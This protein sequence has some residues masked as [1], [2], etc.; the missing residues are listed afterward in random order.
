MQNC[1]ETPSSSNSNSFVWIGLAVLGLVL[2]V[3]HML[4]ASRFGLRCRLRNTIVVHTFLTTWINLPF[5]LDA[6]FQPSMWGHSTTGGSGLLMLGLVSGWFNL[7]HI[8]SAA[9]L[10]RI[11]GLVLFATAAAELVERAFT[12]LVYISGFQREFTKSGLLLK[13]QWIRSCLILDLDV[14]VQP[15]VRGMVVHGDTTKIRSGL[16]LSFA[17]DRFSWTILTSANWLKWTRFLLGLRWLRKPAQFSQERAVSF[18][19]GTHIH[20]LGLSSPISTW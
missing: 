5:A 18:V 17:L 2:F 20:A 10:K 13:V 11:V 3:L 15:C 4:S 6:S 19:P 7:M 9:M 14:P 8:I 16:L 1:A 12:W